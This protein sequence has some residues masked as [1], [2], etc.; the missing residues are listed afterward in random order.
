MRFEFVS[1][2]SVFDVHFSSVDAMSG[3]TPLNACIGTLTTQSRI[4]LGGETNRVTA[5]VRC[6]FEQMDGALLAK[7]S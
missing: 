6:Q 2:Q 1:L 3:R 7:K 4:F 5:I